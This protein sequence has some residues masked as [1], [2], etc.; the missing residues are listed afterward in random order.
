[1][2]SF[3]EIEIKEESKSRFHRELERWRVELLKAYSTAGDYFACLDSA[4]RAAVPRWEN[5]DAKS[6]TLSPLS[7][8]SS[9]RHHPSSLLNPE[10]RR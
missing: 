10:L 2:A 8:H 3:M 7:Y 6:T 4:A 5:R 1:M 9:A